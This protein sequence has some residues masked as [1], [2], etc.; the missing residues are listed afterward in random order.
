MV[1]YK[2]VSFPMF[3]GTLHPD[4]NNYM[5]GLNKDRHPTKSLALITVG[6]II[7]YYRLISIM[8]Q[9]EV[10]GQLTFLSFKLN[11]Q[12]TDTRNDKRR[13][14]RKELDFKP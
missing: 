12:S 2:H 1:S 11:V 8:K 5:F 6:I 9:I 3:Q 13:L 7:I 14:N 10:I 4:F